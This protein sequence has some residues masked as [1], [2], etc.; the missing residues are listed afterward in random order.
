[1]LRRLFTII[2]L[3]VS[4]SACSIFGHDRPEP[5]ANLSTRI[6]ENGTKFFTFALILPNRN[7]RD[8]ARNKPSRANMPPM[9]ATKFSGRNKRQTKRLDQ[10]M[11]SQLDDQL[12]EIDYCHTGYFILNKSAQ[13]GRASITGECKEGATHQDRQRFGVTRHF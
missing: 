5:K 11:E 4:L 2:S 3:V 9:D 6:T 8:S 7:E 13:L 12:A 10:N 1:M